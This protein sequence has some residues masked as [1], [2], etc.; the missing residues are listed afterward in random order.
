MFCLNCG[1]ELPD[2]AKFCSGCGKQIETREKE[3]INTL[4]LCSSCGEELIPG[5][6]FCTKCGAS[7]EGLSNNQNNSTKVT[8]EDQNFEQS[9][10][11]YEEGSRLVR[12]TGQIDGA[13]QKFTE[14][15]NLYPHP[16]Y[17]FFRGFTYLSIDW[18]GENINLELV[19][20][21]MSNVI[22][23]D[24]YAGVAYYLRG[25]AYK[26]LWEQKHPEYKEQAIADFEKALSLGCEIGFADYIGVNMADTQ[27][28]RNHLN[29]LKKGVLKG[30]F[31][32]LFG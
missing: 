12:D 27:W 18:T 31:S 19:I 26:S 30:M 22:A 23:L 8:K 9:Q 24:P 16:Y 32:N 29:I 1:K 28:A 13:I 7:L 21:D 10:R 14:A 25:I 2:D 3:T 11:L 5:N 15:I 20:Q 4:P 6:K 17:Y